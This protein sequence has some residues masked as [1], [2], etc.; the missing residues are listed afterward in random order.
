MWGR[1]KAAPLPG[2]FCLEKYFIKT[3]E[4]FIFDKGD[5]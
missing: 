5:V 2:I 3:L 4:T 1:G